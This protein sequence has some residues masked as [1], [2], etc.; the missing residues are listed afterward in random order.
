MELTH[1]I[2]KPHIQEYP[3]NIL[4]HIATPMASKMHGMN[5]NSNTTTLNFFSDFA[6]SP[7]PAVIKIEVNAI[8]LEKEKEEKKKHKK[9]YRYN[10]SQYVYCSQ[11]RDC[12]PMNSK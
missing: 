10:Q 7:K 1:P 8:S 4:Q 9:I 12:F 3:N 5:D 2:N 11:F 6:S